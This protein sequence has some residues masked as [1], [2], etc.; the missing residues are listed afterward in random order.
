MATKSAADAAL[1]RIRKLCA[2]ID[3]AEEKLSHGAPAFFA[4][5][6]QFLHFWNNHHGDARL[7]VWCRADPEARDA[8]LSADPD[9][10]FLPPY[11]AHL[12]WVGIRLE[13][14]PPW[15]RVEAIV[16]EAANAATRSR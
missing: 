7:A 15:K 16:R 12:G 1:T 6:K 8:W 5:K 2:G 4:G 10:F 9:R 3:G 14:R 13:G 11:V